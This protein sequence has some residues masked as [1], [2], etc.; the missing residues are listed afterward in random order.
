MAIFSRFSEVGEGGDN[1]VTY[2]EIPTT[3]KEIE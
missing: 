1:N 2:H 3:L